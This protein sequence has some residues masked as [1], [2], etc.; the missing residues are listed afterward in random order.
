[1]RTASAP[2]AAEEWQVEL[3]GRRAAARELDE[4]SDADALLVYGSDG[5]AE[6]F[7]YLTNFQPVLGSMWLLLRAGGEAFCALDFH[8]QLEEARRR[9]GIADWHG[10][11][12]P[13]NAVAARVR[14][15]RRLAVVGLDRLPV[16]EW[17]RLRAAAPDAELVDATAELA[18]PRRRKSE[19]ELR[20]LR[21]AAALTDEA[22]DT[23]RAELRPGL[24][25]REVAARL[26][27]V[28]RRGSGEWAFTPCVVS[29][30][31]DPIPIREP[32]DRVLEEGDTVMVD[33]GG[34][35]DG[36]Q[37]DASRTWVLGEPSEAQARAWEVVVR[38]HA[39]AFER[40]A[41]GV[42]GA[43]V[44]RA[45]ADV[46]GAAGYEL[47]HR[48]GHGIGLATSFEWPSLDHD[49]T[50]LAP[51]MTFCV[52]PGVYVV[53]AGNVKLEDDVAVTDDGY[54]L[55]TN[56]SRELAVET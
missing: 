17:E 42:P 47:G 20:C 25:E 46:V 56:A 23:V 15:A 5:H 51:G 54:E 45:A 4:R 49:D 34:S 43:E 30:V 13:A 10:A 26:G 21:A 28:L 44:A 48:V 36:Y 2:P 1:M 7:R 6:P 41:P 50:P 9:S 29:G 22:L 11:P 16:T 24:T 27:Y 37:A 32:T 8:W 14:G 12:G 55:L 53:G 31:D 40:I 19:L 18:L 33:V 39:A 38:A 52:E 3:A 35:W